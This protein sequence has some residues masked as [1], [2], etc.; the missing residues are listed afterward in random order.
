MTRNWK[1]NLLVL[2]LQN[3]HVSF[4]REVFLPPEKSGT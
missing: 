4:T 1:N 2:D 3:D